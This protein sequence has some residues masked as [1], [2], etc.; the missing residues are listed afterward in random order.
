MSARQRSHWD[1][2]DHFPLGSRGLELC[3]VSVTSELRFDPDDSQVEVDI[4]PAQPERLTD[5]QS[6]LGEEFEQR[7]VRLCVL[8]QVGEFGS[9]E[10]RNSFRLPPRLLTRFETSD[11][12]SQRASLAAV[13][14]EC[15]SLNGSTEGVAR[16]S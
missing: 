2:Q 5:P 14:R 8:E 1:G 10:D 16:V 4:S 3:R 9:L 11:R 7:P 15:C 6:R 12:G 13:R